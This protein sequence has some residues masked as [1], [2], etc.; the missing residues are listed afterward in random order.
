MWLFVGPTPLAGIGQVVLKYAEIAKGDWIQFGATTTNRYENVF[1]FLLPIETNIKLVKNYYEGIGKNLYIMTICE[2]K[3][4]HPDYSKIFNTFPNA[5]HLTPSQ[6]CADIFNEQFGVSLKVIPLWS[7]V[8][9][10]TPVPDSEPYTFYTIGNIIDPRKNIDKLVSAFALCDFPRGTARLILK[11][12]CRRDVYLDIPDVEVING[13]LSDEEL[14]KQIHSRAHCYINFSHSEGVGMG[15]VEAAL[16][17][18]PVVIATFGGLKEYIS[19]PFLINC[20]ETTVGIKDFL[21]SPDMVW[22]EPD[23]MQL[24]SFMK[25][26]YEKKLVRQEHPCTVKLMEQPFNFFRAE[27]KN[28]CIAN[29]P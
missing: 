16:R 15:A 22:G 23:S 4:V 29:S 2:T 3:P 17:E 25:E 10:W 20:S 13:L 11:A 9:E 21:F 19:T 14:E 5:T 6:F 28:T 8:K 12:T 18:K 27:C 24:I 26:C 7:P 1:V